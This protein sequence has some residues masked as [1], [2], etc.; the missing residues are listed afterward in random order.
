[1]VAIRSWIN[2]T[3]EFHAENRER[4]SLLLGRHGFR[5]RRQTMRSG[6]TQSSNCS[7]V[8]VPRASAASRS[9]RPLTWAW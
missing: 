5:W 9:D 3:H 1:M 6:L 4:G 7:P 8:T 2:G